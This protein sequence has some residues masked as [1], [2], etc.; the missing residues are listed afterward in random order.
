MQLAIVIGSAW[1]TKK[2]ERLVGQ[3]LM[4][5]KDIDL[6]DENMKTTPYIAIDTIG[7]GNGEKVIVVS[8]S[9]ARVAAK[10]SDIPVDMAIVGIVDDEEVDKRYL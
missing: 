4:I 6:L 5:V 3:K 8:G 7:A 10:S 9:A 1:S 2:E